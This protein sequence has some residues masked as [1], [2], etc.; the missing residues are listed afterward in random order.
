MAWGANRKASPRGPLAQINAYGVWGLAAALRGELQES[1]LPVRVQ[2]LRVGFNTDDGAVGDKPAWV[3]QRAVP[4]S[5]CLGE[6]V[7]GIAAA[8]AGA[9]DVGFEMISSDQ[10]A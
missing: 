6:A 4:M 5:Q 8:G 2:E 7:A 10:V 1:A 9:E 3:A